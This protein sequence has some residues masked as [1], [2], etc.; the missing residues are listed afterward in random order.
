MTDERDIAETRVRE[1]FGLLLMAYSGGSGGD[2]IVKALLDA[3]EAVK[4][5]CDDWS[6]SDPGVRPDVIAGAYGFRL[7]ERA[8][9]APRELI[10]EEYEGGRLPLVYGARE[11]E[12]VQLAAKRL[13]HALL[14]IPGRGSRPSQHLRILIERIGAEH[15][16]R[17]S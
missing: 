10:D 1:L 4:T 11:P 6:A 12:I 13:A 9:A 14:E 5:R 2:R 15:V 3:A 17:W 7:A 16:R 8:L